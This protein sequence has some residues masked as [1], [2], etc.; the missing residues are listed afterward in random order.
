MEYYIITSSWHIINKCKTLR[1]AKISYKRKW[2]TLY[3][4][5]IIISEKD[6]YETQPMVEST[7][8]M[9]GKKIMIPASE[10]NTYLD[11]GTERYW[12]S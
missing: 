12:S 11:P 5:S 1:G 7:N 9:S 8:L 6:F 10:K 2:K 3:P 4:D